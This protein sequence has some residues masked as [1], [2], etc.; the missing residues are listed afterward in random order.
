MEVGAA[1]ELEGAVIRGVMTGEEVTAVVVEGAVIRGVMTG[2]E[3]TG[4]VGGG[5]SPP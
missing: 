2:E 5:G 1:A 3:V 4:G